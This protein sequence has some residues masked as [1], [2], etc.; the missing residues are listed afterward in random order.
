[1]TEPNRSNA[2]KPNHASAP[3]DGVRLAPGI[4]VTPDVLRFSFVRSGGPG[5]QNVNKVA[6]KAELRVRL[7]DL[8][9][10]RHT[11]D[12]LPKLAGRRLTSEGELLISAESTRS[13]LRNREECLLKL[14]D[15]LVQAMFRP[16]PRKR[17][18]PSRGAI[19][20]RLQA[21]RERSDAKKRRNWSEE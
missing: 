20:R 16:K 21:K 4:L 18:K 9:L 13:Q 6:T 3:G 2:P 8:P 12:R 10:D 1:M 19:E 11:L 14:R 5:G 15:L 17:T 7:S